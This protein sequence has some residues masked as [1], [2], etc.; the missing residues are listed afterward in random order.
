MIRRPPRST[1][2]Y[3]L[4]PYTTLFRSALSCRGAGARRD[5]DRRTLHVDAGAGAE[6]RGSS[7]ARADHRQ[8]RLWQCELGERDVE[9]APGRSV[10]DSTDLYG[11]RRALWIAAGQWRDGDGLRPWAGGLRYIRGDLAAR[12]HDNADHGSGRRMA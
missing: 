7:R 6:R 5:V 2:T 9:Y 12:L 4:V 11:R 8:L 1:R 10:V 3:T